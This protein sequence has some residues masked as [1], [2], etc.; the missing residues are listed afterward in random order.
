MTLAEYLNSL[1]RG[2][3]QAFAARLGTSPDYLGL[4]AR[5]ERRP[6]AALAVAIERESG[7]Q[8]TVETLLPEVDWPVVRQAAA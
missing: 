2:S 5:G 3:R 6:G 1:P 8:V 4:L 7:R